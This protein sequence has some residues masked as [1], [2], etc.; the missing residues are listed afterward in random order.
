M[1][2]ASLESVLRHP[3]P[4]A[5]NACFHPYNDLLDLIIRE[6]STNK[7][8]GH[9]LIRAVTH[10][11]KPNP[12]DFIFV[13]PKSGGRQRR[14]MQV[15]TQETERKMDAW[16]IARNSQV[17]VRV[18]RFCELG[19]FTKEKDFY[20][21]ICE[22]LSDDYL[23]ADTLVIQMDPIVNRDHFTHYLHSKYLI[24]EACAAMSLKGSKFKKTVILLVYMNRPRISRITGNIKWELP[25]IFT[26]GWKN[27]F[28]DALL[29]SE[30]KEYPEIQLTDLCISSPNSQELFAGRV[31][32]RMENILNEAYT[33]T[34]QELKALGGYFLQR[35]EAN[36]DKGTLFSR[37]QRRME[38]RR[39]IDFPTEFLRRTLE[40]RLPR[41]GSLRRLVKDRLVEEAKR[42][43]LNIFGNF[44]MI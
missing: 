44:E 1:K 23:D 2:N 34:L 9:V 15:Y 19:E 21:H 36:F 26:K 43:Y 30:N 6:G 10:D 28:I 3:L 35:R 40:G 38:S 39:D 12:N 4:I 7:S 24:E 31:K 41:R 8:S 14:R 11:I 25:L 29:P 33:K 17:P 42:I 18:V 13:P 27:V 37:V 16:E 20:V 32:S 5:R 22:F